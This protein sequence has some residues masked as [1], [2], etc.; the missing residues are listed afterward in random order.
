MPL[1]SQADRDS[2]FFECPH[3]L[4]DTCALTWFAK[5][6]N[7]ISLLYSVMQSYLLL[8]PTPVLYELAFGAASQSDPAER[9]LRTMLF[10]S[11]RHVDMIHYA[12]THQR[13][14]VR[15]GSF[16]V[17]NPGFNEWWTARDRLLIYSD[18]SRAST[19]SV[20]KNLSMDALIHACARNC[21]APICTVNVADF[22]KLNM[23]SN[24]RSHDREVPYFTPEQVIAS[25]ND[26][27]FFH[28]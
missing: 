23:A 21:F 6:E 3:L 10:K 17:I 19:G 2:P 16:I 5:N 9:D 4:M 14:E 8:I 18:I 1:S 11:N 24:S 20:K 26:E 7:G 13:R 12:F 15:P 27:V 28:P 25:L 22:K